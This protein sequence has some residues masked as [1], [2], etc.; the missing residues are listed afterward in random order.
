MKKV[1]GSKFSV[2]RLAVLGVILASLMCPA[3]F[4]EVTETESKEAPQACNGSTVAFTFDFPVDATDE[5]VVKLRTIATG[6]DETLEENTAYT[7]SAVNNDLSAGGTCTTEAAYSSAYTICLS[8]KTTQTQNT[9]LRDTGALR[10][11]AM[12]SAIDKLTR[13]VQELQ[14]EIARA[15]RIPIS[16]TGITT[17]LDNSVG[18]AGKVLGCDSAG[19]LTM[20]DSIPEGS[21]TVST[22]MGTVNAS[23]DADAAKTLLEVPTITA[24]AETVLDDATVGAMLTTMGGV[25]NTGNETI[26]GNKTFSGTTTLSGITTIA[27]A[28]LMASTAAPTTDAMV[29]NKKYADDQHEPYA[30]MY[31]TAA[32]NNLTDVTWTTVSLDTDTFDFST[33]TDLSNY[34]ITPAVAG[35]YLVIGQVS[36]AEASLVASKTYSAQIYK[37]GTTAIKTVHKSIGAAVTEDVTVPVSDVVLLDADD[38]IQLRAYVNCGASTVD[39]TTG[40]ANTNLVLFRL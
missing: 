2:R 25:A 16:D 20:L 1:Q 36:Y 31:L 7:I 26:A 30:R 35:Y 5:V 23:A 13:I 6:D 19:N 33:I 17:T 32:Q 37:N 3:A 12:Q 18:R 8:R 21:V 29:A 27:D 39:L 4:G 28:S 38:Y 11:S 24:A 22:F 40:T 34:K 15:P 14:E 10:F 9:K